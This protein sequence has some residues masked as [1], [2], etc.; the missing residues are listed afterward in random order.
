M[1]SPKGA[2][3]SSPDAGALTGDARGEDGQSP[4][5]FQHEFQEDRRGASDRV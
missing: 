1:I 2:A 5:M 4:G 3:E